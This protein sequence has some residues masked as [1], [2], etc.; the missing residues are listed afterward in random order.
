[1][2]GNNLH[3]I[4]AHLNKVQSNKKLTQAQEQ[5][6]KYTNE[7]FLQFCERTSTQYNFTYAW[8]KY[9][10]QEQSKHDIILFSIPPQHGKSTV[11]T[12]H[13]AAYFL[14][15]YPTQRG[16]IISYNS[17]ITS[18]FH[19]EI[20]QILEKEGLQLYSK[21]QKEIVHN[22][23]IGSISFCGFQG[24]ITSKPADWIIIDDPIKSASDAYSPNYQEILK[25][26]FATS[27]VPR[28]QQKFKLYCTQTRWHDKDLIGQIISMNEELGANLNI[29]YINLP[30]ICDSDDDPLGREIGEVL[31]PERFT[32]ETIKT[33]MLLAEGD[34]YALYQGRPAPPDGAMFKSEDIEGEAFVTLDDI[35][36]NTI[37]FISV[38][39][40]FK[41]TINS[42]YVAIGVYKYDIK[43][44]TLFKINSVNSKLDFDATVKKVE[45]L[46]KLNKCNFALI[47]DKANGSAV[48]N[49]LSKKF[50]GK[51][52]PINPEGGKVARAYAAQPFIKTKRFKVFKNMS[53]Y[54]AFINQM[55]SFPKGAHDDMVDETTQAINYIN[56]NY[57][58]ISFSEFN[59]GM[60]EIGSMRF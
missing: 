5:S 31:C 23:L 59:Q 47:E 60:Q 51:L 35:P 34:G 53:N 12:I 17:D 6:N 56:I 25:S 48:I 58:A 49:T 21:S 2:Q 41:D 26:G 24:G 36:K 13:K 8:I 39:C 33:K 50:H 9:V 16:I 28:L 29:K 30:A 42:D 54:N 15:R 37:N 46:M 3:S 44:Q 20:L 45:E 1:M 52:I 32:L 10:E 27:I 43:S 40:A 38:D 14:L 19:R 57:N 4:L 18:R 55:K 22:N 11:F 7:T